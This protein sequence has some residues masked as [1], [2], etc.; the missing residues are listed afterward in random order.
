MKKIQTCL[1]YDGNG[2]E[3]AEYY[4]SVFKNRGD[5]RI[6]GSAPGPDGKPLVVTFRLAGVDY[7]ALNGGTYYKLTPAAS[8]SVECDTQEEIDE[9][10]DKLLAGGE[11][12]HC[13]W[14]TDRFGLSWQIVPTMLSQLVADPVRGPKAMGAVMTMIKLDIAKIEAA[15]NT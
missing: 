4:V 3:A 6:T 12:S 15:A 7:M 10:W 11:P 9:Y 13:G 8:I 5:T 2:H 14:L 1:W